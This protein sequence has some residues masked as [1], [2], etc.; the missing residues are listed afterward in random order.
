MKLTSLAI[1]AKYGIATPAQMN[2]LALQTIQVARKVAHSA[3]ERKL[4]PASEVEDV[5]MSAAEKA[6]N[7]LDGW[8]LQYE[9]STFIGLITKSQVARCKADY[10]KQRRVRLIIPEYLP[11]NLSD[12]DR[13]LICK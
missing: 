2:D 11:E 3:V 6:L 1:L 5:A 8:K 10:A 9:F 13:K 12:A 7:S 4:I